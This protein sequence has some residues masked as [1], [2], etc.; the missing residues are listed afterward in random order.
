MTAETSTPK[1]GIAMPTDDFPDRSDAEIA[2]IVNEAQTRGEV[3]AAIATPSNGKGARAANG[4]YADT[5]LDTSESVT[6]LTMLSLGG[7][8]YGVELLQKRMGE[9]K[10][11]IVQDRL[12]G[13]GVP[14]LPKDELARYALIGLALKAPTVLKSGSS[15]I[16]GVA[17]AATNVVTGLTNPIANSFLFRPLV[18]RYDAMADRGASMVRELAVLGV[19]GE[20]YSKSLVETTAFGTMSDVV[21]VV[22]EN[23]EV[24]DLVQQQTV[25]LLQELLMFVQDRLEGADMLLQRITFRIIPGNQADREVKPEIEIPL[26]EKNRALVLSA[27]RVR[28]QPR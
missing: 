19:E 6:G 16:E 9:T 21:D 1:N 4:L 8:L 3:R 5:S 11:T 20:K 24:R 18:R 26:P 7:L 25:G 10:A 2:A 17:D 27:K 12:A 23:E 13:A 15:R 14:A 22:V 28:T